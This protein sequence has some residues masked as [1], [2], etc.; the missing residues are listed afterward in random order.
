MHRAG[1]PAAHGGR[2]VTVANAG[3]NVYVSLMAHAAAMVGN[4]SSGLV[5]APSFKL[6]VVN[7]GTRQDGK[8]KPANVI[9]TGYDVVSVTQGLTTA[10]GPA[11]RQS[12]AD[13]VNPYGEG[14]AGQRIA[15]ILADL[16]IS[17]RLLRKKFIDL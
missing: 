3:G 10:L 5:E 8:I 9:N 2:A 16:D 7:I 4:S 17:P 15:A 11:F 1:L 6:P 14:R 12:L 13:L